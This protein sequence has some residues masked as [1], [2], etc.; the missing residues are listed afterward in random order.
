[1]SNTHAHTSHCL[2]HKNYFQNFLPRTI[3]FMWS[4][5]NFLAKI[6]S[7]NADLQL[8][9]NKMDMTACKRCQDFEI[10]YIHEKYN[11]V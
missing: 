3:A 8:P 6:Q 10:K 2:K 4:G 1:M 9:E 5:L 7:L 11:T